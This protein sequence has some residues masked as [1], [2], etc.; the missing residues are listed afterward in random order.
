LAVFRKERNTAFS[1]FYENKFRR[2]HEPKPLVRGEKHAN[3]YKRY[4]RF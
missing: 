2:N 3:H 4:P 1:N